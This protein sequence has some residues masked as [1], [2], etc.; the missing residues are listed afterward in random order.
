M[1]EDC[2]LKGL[3]EDCFEDG[4][5][6]PERCHR[7]GRIVHGDCTGIDKGVVYCP[8]CGPGP[9]RDK[10]FPYG[11]PEIFQDGRYRVTWYPTNNTNP[12]P[13]YPA[14]A[15]RI[16]PTHQAAMVEIFKKFPAYVFK[17]VLEHAAIE[18]W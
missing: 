14:P 3:C 5:L 12:P 10:G 11:I 6:D 4:P 15:S 13:N 1:I 7:C 18:Y 9:K 8:I 16:F 17:A 2:G